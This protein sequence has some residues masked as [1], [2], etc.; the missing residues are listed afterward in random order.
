MIDTCNI[1]NITLE[2]IPEDLVNG[3]QT[4]CQ[5]FEPM[6]IQIYAIWSHPNHNESITT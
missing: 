2:W 4:L 6:L 5:V 1:L 3:K